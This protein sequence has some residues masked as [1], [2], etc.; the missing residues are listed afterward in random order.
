MPYRLLNMLNIISGF[1]QD[2][3]LPHIFSI[4]YEFTVEFKIVK[5]DKKYY[6]LLELKYLNDF[7]AIFLVPPS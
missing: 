5:D 4:T 6:S 2:S 7:R 3:L 1:K